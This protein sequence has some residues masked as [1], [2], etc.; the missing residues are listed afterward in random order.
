MKY[1]SISETMINKKITISSGIKKRIKE[2]RHLEAEFSTSD[3]Q[4]IV[5]AISW[6]I[7]REN[8][9]IVPS[10]EKI[11]FTSNMNSI[12]LDYVYKGK[13]P[14]SC[15][16][17]LQKFLLQKMIRQ[18]RNLSHTSI[19][20]FK[21]NTM[22]FHHIRD[23][24]DVKIFRGDISPID[25]KNFD[26]TKGLIMGKELGSSMSEGPGIYFTSNIKDAERYGENITVAKIEK[27]ANIITDYSEKI[28]TEKIKKILDMID[29]EILDIALSN[30]N[31]NPY[32]AKKMII[33]EIN[34][35]DNPKEQLMSIWA[36]VFYHQNPHEFIDVIVKNGIDGIKVKKQGFNHYII[37]NKMSVRIVR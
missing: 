10:T 6:D 8:D 23:V 20:E 32:I 11:F 16:K 30:F 18:K 36:D 4:A 22:V 7:Q 34:K 21:K 2:L 15:F 33:D 14:E 3:L 28:K 27:S 37:Y 5:T 24:D 12:I 31:E 13:T 19:N 25:L 9:I 26:A 1:T 17:E 29:K 35:Y